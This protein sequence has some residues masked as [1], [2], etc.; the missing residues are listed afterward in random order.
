MSGRTGPRPL[1][2]KGHHLQRLP[3]RR[4]RHDPYPCPGRGPSWRPWLSQGN[5][6]HLIPV[7]LGR[8]GAKSWMISWRIYRLQDLSKRFWHCLIWDCRVFHLTS[9]WEVI[10]KDNPSSSVESVTVNITLGSN[11]KLCSFS[12]A[13]S[14]C[15]NVHQCAIISFHHELEQLAEKHVT[16]VVGCI[17]RALAKLARGQMPDQSDQNH[18]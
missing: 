17:L 8:F 11:S 1:S 12:P 15:T 3:G 18:S 10:V 13:S 4:A 7:D 16:F 5:G 9:V 2:A 14:M 6:T